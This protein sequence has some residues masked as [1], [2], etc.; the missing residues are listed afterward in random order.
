MVEPSRWPVRLTAAAEADFRE[1]LRW[2]TDRF[3]RAQARSYARTLSAAIEALA[4][5]P[6]VV[7]ARMRDDVSNGL[8]TLHVAR[9]G[10]KGRHLVMFQ[11]GRDRDRDVIEVLRVVH[12]SMDLPRHVAKTLDD[13]DEA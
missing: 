5:G 9:G 8:F 3:G 2:T 4:E 7:G 12:D 13:R 11:V 6:S 10:R 1:I